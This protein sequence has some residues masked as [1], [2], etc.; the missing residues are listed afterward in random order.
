MSRALRVALGAV[1]VWIGVS[2][3]S[4]RAQDVVLRTLLGASRADVEAT[5]V[6]T[7]TDGDWTRYGDALAIRY[8][9]GIATHVRARSSATSCDD[10]ARFA[11]FTAPPGVFPLRR[12]DGCEW[13]ALSG[14]HRLAPHVA[15]RFAAGVIE[16]WSE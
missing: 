16:I 12:A 11:G 3:S 10:A 9:N 6:A 8:E 2:A 4:A 14:R 5:H 1:L 15:A 13:P 7:G